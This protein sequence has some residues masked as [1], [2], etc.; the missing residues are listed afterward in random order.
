MLF[1]VEGDKATQEVEALESGIL[2]IP[3][4]APPP[5][6]E[7]PVGTLL[8]YLLAAGEEIEAEA[9]SWKLELGVRLV[10]QQ[11]AIQL[12]S[13]P[14]TSVPAPSFQSTSRTAI[15]PRARRVAGELGVDWA[16]LTGS[17]RT[18]RIVE[19]DV[20]Q[21]A[22]ARSASAAITPSARWRAAWPPSWAWTW[23]RWPPGC[24]A[25]ASSAPTSRRRPKVAG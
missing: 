12:L 8:G 24:P 21:A 20:R 10:C 7:V 22:A 4:D 13:D 11:S 18:G 15:S 2:R 16:G 9:R 14:R 6:K 1:T 19:R 3:P 23:T 17:G 5:G 25:S